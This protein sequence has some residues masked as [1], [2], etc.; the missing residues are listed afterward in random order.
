MDGGIWADEVKNYFPMVLIISCPPPA[1]SFGIEGPEPG[2]L[3]LGF[4]V[5]VLEKSEDPWT[6]IIF[7]TQNYVMELVL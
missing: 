6:H 4:P 7:S 2:Y 3:D 5:H 1:S